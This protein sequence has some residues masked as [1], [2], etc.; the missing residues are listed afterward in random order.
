MPASCFFV[1]HSSSPPARRILVVD[2]DE[3]LLILM[4]EAL[5]EEKYE[6][7][8]ATSARDAQESLAAQPPDV[9]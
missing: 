1:P 2:D 5:R 4:A 8:T 3:G 6:V 7:F 9:N